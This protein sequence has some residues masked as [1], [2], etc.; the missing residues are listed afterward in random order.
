MSKLWKKGILCLLAAVFLFSFP[1]QAENE[2]LTYRF[3]SIDGK[4][5]TNETN[6]GKTTLIVFLHMSSS[7][8]DAAELVENIL[9]ADWS[10]NP[11]LSIIAADCMGTAE[12][13]IR[14]FA[15]PYG[16]TD[17]T[18]CADE[19]DVF[20][21][22][23]EAAGQSTNSFSVPMSFVVD[24]EGKV[25]AA[26]AGEYSENA[27]RN[28]LAPYVEDID[29]VPTVTLSIPG[30]NVYSEAFE[31]LELINAERKKEG[32]PEVKMDKEL[33]DAAMLRAAECS[34]YYSHTR[35]NGTQCF[36]AFPAGAGA[37]GENIA[38]GQQSAE[39]VMDGWMN[40]QGH[41]ANILNGSYNSVGV[42]VFCHQGI[43][44][45][46]Q[47]F[48]SDTAQTVKKPADTE[49][50]VKIEVLQENLLP[51]A[52]RSLLMLQKGTEKSVDLEF[53]N[54]EFAYHYAQPDPSCL[55]FQSSDPRVAP[56]DQ[57]GVVT[58]AA[59]GTAL[60]TVTVAGTD[61][62]LTVEIVVTE[63][64]YDEWQYNAPTCSDPGSA[65]YRCLDC[66]QWLDREVLQL[67]PHNWDGGTVTRKPTTEKEGE[68]RY[69]CT[70][71]GKTKIQ[72]IPKYST[73]KPVP[74]QPPT[75]APTK[76]PTTAP[77]A[78][79]T[80]P[81]TKAP[82]APPATPAVT[83]PTTVATNPT[84]LPIPVPEPT[85]TTTESLPTEPTEGVAEPVESSP[86]FIPETQPTQAQTQL[87]TE[88]EDQGAEDADKKLTIAIIVVAAAVLAAGAFLLFWKRK[89]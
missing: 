10:G 56:V 23:M 54:K 37:S 5:L 59:E 62:Q 88:P 25:Q 39:E 41:R 22:C 11:N 51:R 20:F 53:I 3:T 71:C 68:R 32:L 55:R 81:P 36:T 50:T 75:A 63:H 2:S 14:R 40:S 84:E 35:P 29:P 78:A 6:A 44:T 34:V 64:N 13:E 79:P 4:T 28:L 67:Q 52:E 66:E 17:I 60:I 33:L 18:F 19:N 38:I 70:D 24:Q 74:T 72:S 48:S 87:S 73:P 82:T 85:E 15:A 86:E 42:G 26:M 43:Y 21:S 31:I 8:S 61:L 77:T 1:V 89:Q 12:E 9:N 27:F 16:D 45:W 47:V 30:E 83:Q 57:Q 7:H 49:K 65:R 76:A 58:A 80:A 69:T 46:V